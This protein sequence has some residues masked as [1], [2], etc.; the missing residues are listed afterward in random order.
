MKGGGHERVG[1]D[2]HVADGI[3]GPLL[4]PGRCFWDGSITNTGGQ[5]H[6]RR[7]IRVL[8]DEHYRI[9]PLS[10]LKMSARPS[11]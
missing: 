11:Q 7:V 6:F 1:P 4:I 5:R 2:L 8:T 10:K 9:S 3:N